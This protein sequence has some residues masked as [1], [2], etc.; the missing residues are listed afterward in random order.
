[1]DVCNFVSGI[2][3]GMTFYD[4]GLTPVLSGK[5][6]PVLMFLA[7]FTATI[8]ILGFEIIARCQLDPSSTEYL[9]IALI[10]NVMDSLSAIPYIYSLISRLVAIMPLNPNNEYFYTIM[11][12]PLVY[13]IVDIYGIMV[14]FGCPFN[15]RLASTLFALGNVAFGTTFFS[16]DM[17][18]TYWLIKNQ[19]TP[20][21]IDFFP[22]VGG[23][24]YIATALAATFDSAIDASPLYLAYAI[25]IF[26]YQIVSR[27]LTGVI[28]GRTSSVQSPMKI[29]SGSKT[30]NSLY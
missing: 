13:P 2:I 20:N 17:C 26:S 1:M 6:I 4:I 29:P 16:L 24:I 11:V 27:R 15:P 23:L 21:A 9:V 19:P 5:K 30:D 8:Y 22:L 7:A 10:M 3:L 12:I 25:D 14:L 18:V 28:K